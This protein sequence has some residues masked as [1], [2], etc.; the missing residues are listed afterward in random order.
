MT[1]SFNAILAPLFVQVTLTFGLLIWMGVLRV[2]L[3][4]AGSLNPRDVE[5]GQ[6]SWPE[7]VTL[8]ANA[9]QAQFQLPLLFYLAVVL[10]LLVAPGTPFVVPLAWLFVVTRLVHALI[11]V[12]SND[13]TRRFYLFV[14]GVAVLVIIWL[15]LI[16]EIV[17]AL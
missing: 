3:V 16:A 15:I 6:S 4:A 13:V 10:V 17:F 12:T 2:R 7:Q 5:R 8:V 14:A 9:Y 1:M 11:Q